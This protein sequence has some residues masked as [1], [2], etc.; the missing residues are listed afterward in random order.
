MSHCAE[1]KQL[2][3]NNETAVAAKLLDNANLIKDALR[4]FLILKLFRFRNYFFHQQMEADFRFF[5]GLGL[6]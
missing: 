5:M 2:P 3:T 6:L 4:Y 1:L